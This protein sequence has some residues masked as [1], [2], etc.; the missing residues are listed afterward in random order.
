MWSAQLIFC[1]INRGVFRIQ[2]NIVNCFRKK[3]S[4]VAVPLGFNY[5]SDKNTN[6]L[7]WIYASYYYTLENRGG[8]LISGGVGK[9]TKS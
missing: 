1:S 7:T 4:V 6:K 9:T 2:S 8:L 5:A 3:G